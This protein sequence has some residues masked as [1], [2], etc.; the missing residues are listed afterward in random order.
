MPREQLAQVLCLNPNV[1]ALPEVARIV[2]DPYRYQAPLDEHRVRIPLR[3]Q[4]KLIP[5]VLLEPGVQ[6]LA[7]SATRELAP[8][9][10]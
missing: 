1:S 2:V 10:R 9:A 6:R 7:S 5:V 3:H 4:Q 8:R